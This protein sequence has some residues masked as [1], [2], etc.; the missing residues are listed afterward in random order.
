MV[1]KR[2]GP[3]KTILF[4]SH[5]GGETHITGAE[6][7]L[8]ILLKELRGKYHCILV[9]PI[10]S[11]L[12]AKVRKLGIEVVITPYSM[13][14]SIWKPDI[15]L[16]HEE[17]RLLSDQSLQKLVA[18]MKEKKA[19]LVITNTCVN[20][21]PAVA[22]K[23]SGIPVIWIV[24]EV[25]A[26]NAFTSEAV[27]L[28]NRYSDWIVGI[29]N[30]VI[31]PFKKE[32]LVRKTFFLYPTTNIEQRKLDT[33]KRNRKILR[34]QLGL[35]N[36]DKLVAFVAAYISR[37]KGFDH[38]IKMAI[39]LCE[40]CND[41][42]FLI[43]GK[44]TDE[45]F[46]NQCIQLIERSGHKNKFHIF[47]FE[48]DIYSIYPAIDIMVIPSLIDEG[49]SLVCLESLFFGKPVVA[50]QSGGII[51]QMNRTNNKRFLVEKGNINGLDI[52]VSN[53]LKN[54][55]LRAKVGRSNQIAS[56]HFYGVVPFRKRLRLLFKKVF[57]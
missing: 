12:A 47:S 43:V 57:G 15:M 24:C 28:I 18:I 26:D 21:L 44:P 52:K 25:I 10:Q 23:K 45:A 11:L 6:N 37:I 13:L 55:L 51:E 50:Y 35:K 7:Y 9:S 14:W 32:N 27:Q 30:A 8:L 22:A 53:L 39:S 34:K 48:E 42:H 40:K 4:F 36:S 33:L 17:Q 38:Y 2:K 56:N 19:D 5:R 46:Y 29:S 31:T 54:P 16:G 41:V 3:Q 49:F 20:P 1:K